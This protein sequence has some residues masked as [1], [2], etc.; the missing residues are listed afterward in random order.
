LRIFFYECILCITAWYSPRQ[1]SGISCNTL[2]T[3]SSNNNAC[4][5]FGDF[6]T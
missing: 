5:L 4:A 3:A 1:I 6:N 2:L